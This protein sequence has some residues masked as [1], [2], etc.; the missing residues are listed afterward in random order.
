[1]TLIDPSK[2]LSV[3]MA[4]KQMPRHSEQAV[5]RL[6]RLGRLPSIR[7]GRSVFINFDTLTDYLA[8]GHAS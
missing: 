7:I 8:K 2:L 3:S 6:V 1:M 4:A 5:W